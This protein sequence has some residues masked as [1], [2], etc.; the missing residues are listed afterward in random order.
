MQ[1]DAKGKM[2]LA[3]L[4]VTFIPPFV[5][6]TNVHDATLNRASTIHVYVLLIFCFYVKTI[7]HCILQLP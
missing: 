2:F 4:L 1:N 5:L 7:E 6:S 3:H